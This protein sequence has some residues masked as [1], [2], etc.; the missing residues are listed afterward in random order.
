MH[1]SKFVSIF[2]ST[3]DLF[4]YF[5][6]FLFIHFLFAD[7]IVEQLTILHVLHHQE[8]MFGGFNDFIK[9]DDVGMSDQFQNVN[10][11]AD[12]LHICYVYYTI[13]FQNFDSHLFAGGEVCSQFDLSESSLA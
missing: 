13:F 5:T 9:L 7:N 2:D 1:Y 10:L 3:D 4:K 11:P 8:E 6:G 12:S